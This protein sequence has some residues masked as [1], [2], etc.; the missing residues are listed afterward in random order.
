MHESGADLED[1]LLTEELEAVRGELLRV[2]QKSETLLTLAAAGFAVALTG[3][4]PH[5]ALAGR[6]SAAGLLAAGAATMQLL[7]V[8]QPRLGAAWSRRLTR[9]RSGASAGLR[10]W[11]CGE[12]T[13][14]SRIV[15]A[16]YRMLRIAAYLLMCA[17]ALMVAAQLAEGL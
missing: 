1:E 10:T 15:V 2:D 4:R 5:D 16:K 13:A 9:E 14:L 8:V 6:L 12:L 3:G 11:R 17:L 7:L